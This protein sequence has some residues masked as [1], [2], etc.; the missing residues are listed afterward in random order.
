MVK[1]NN[2]K[3]F[4]RYVFAGSLILL[5]LGTLIMTNNVLAGVCPDLRQFNCTVTETCSGEI[6]N[7]YEECF[8]LCINDD[9]ASL[10][11]VNF[12]FNLKFLN[13]KNLLGTDTYSP[14]GGCSVNFKGRSMIVDYIPLIGA[15]GCK[16][17]FQCT[18]CDGCCSG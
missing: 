18:P 5:F 17:H 7:I 16:Y 12:Y 1:S 10:S 6:V 2:C 11:S 4:K 8:N 13:S 15:T 14:V 3:S 9:S